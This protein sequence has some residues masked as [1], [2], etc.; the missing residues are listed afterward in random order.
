M[1]QWV[2]NV[3]GA[4]LRCIQGPLLISSIWENTHHYANI[5]CI[6][7]QL[8]WIGFFM[9]L[10]LIYIH[11]P[12]ILF[13][14]RAKS[15]CV[16]SFF[17]FIL[18]LGGQTSKSATNDIRNDKAAFCNVCCGV[19]GNGEVFWCG[20]WAD[21]DANDQSGTRGSEHQH[22]NDIN[23]QWETRSQRTTRDGIGSKL[24]YRESVSSLATIK[25]H[26]KLNDGRPWFIQ[27]HAENAF[28]YKFVE[29]HSEFQG[30]LKFPK[31]WLKEADVTLRQYCTRNNSN[32]TELKVKQLSSHLYCSQA[33]K[34]VLSLPLLLYI[35]LFL[36]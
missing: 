4:F 3:C 35:Y 2:C 7:Y 20:I 28:K 8:W 5:K 25:Q 32:A 36:C 10:P 12:Q 34:M 23:E 29:T 13:L 15:T 33:E 24:T 22:N 19:N 16:P 18:A 17:V 26:E 9:R 30:L 6:W 14:F 31:I 11:L 21:G 27:T 1:A